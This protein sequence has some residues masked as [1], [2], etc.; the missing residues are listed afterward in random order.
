MTCGG[1]KRAGPCSGETGLCNEM[2]GTESKLSHDMA[3]VGGVESNIESVDNEG[4]SWG[5]EEM[6]G[7]ESEPGA[8]GCFIFFSF[9]DTHG[10]PC[11]SCTCT[12]G[13]QACTS[14]GT[15]TPTY[16]VVVQLILV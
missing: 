9:L 13:V 15:L 1:A 7:V 14:S 4:V 2:E 5:G 3:G 10:V 11:S 16:H 12:D 8:V 6:D